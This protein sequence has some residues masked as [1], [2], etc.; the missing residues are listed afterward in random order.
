MGY[1][2]KNIKPKH[3]K[4]KL[5]KGFYAKVS[6]IKSFACQI[7]SKLVEDGG[8]KDSN[9][10]QNLRFAVAEHPVVAGAAALLSRKEIAP[11]TN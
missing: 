9:I 11:R 7:G 2:T 5:D 8:E 3:Q 1:H 10:P 6:F 4:S